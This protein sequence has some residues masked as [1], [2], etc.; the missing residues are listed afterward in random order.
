MIFA[1]F[2]RNGTDEDIEALLRKMKTL[3][4]RSGQKL[5]ESGLGIPH[6]V[7]SHPLN[8]GEVKRKGPFSP[9]PVGPAIAGKK[10]RRPASLRAGALGTVAI[11]KAVHNHPPVRGGQ[12]KGNF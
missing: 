6:S 2:H 10:L 12:K 9:E 5:I 4:D 11:N 3:M 8:K 7:G 1:L